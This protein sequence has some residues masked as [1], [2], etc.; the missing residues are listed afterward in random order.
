MQY[1]RTLTV[2]GAL[3]LAACGAA[4]GAMG[5]TDFK[6]MQQGIEAQ[7]RAAERACGKLGGTARALCETQAEGH[8]KVAKAQLE[9]RRAPG[10]EADR[11]VKQ[12]QAEADYELARVH[13]DAG[14]GRARK[15]CI[16]QAKAARVAAERLAMVEKVRAQRAARQVRN[17][18]PREDSPKERYAA[19]RA[20]CTIQ[21][22]E[23]DRCLE[24]AKRRFHKS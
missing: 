8:A 4:V 12:A 6:A 16:A 23:R 7:A 2:A 11:R 5:I 10:P 20:Y 19:M 22:M 13:C 21:G 18:P 14:R 15:S 24:E 3:A 17:D 1:G 9:A